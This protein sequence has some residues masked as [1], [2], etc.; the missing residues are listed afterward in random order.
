[1]ESNNTL[2]LSTG[3]AHLD[4]LL[5][6]DR[7]DISENGGILI[8]AGARRDDLETPIVVIEGTTGTGKTTLALQI[9]HSTA[10]N[11][12][13]TVFF[14]SLEQTIQSLKN[15]ALNFDS[16]KERNENT[17][18]AFNEI[19]EQP[20]VNFCDLS[21][22]EQ[23]LEFEAKENKIYFCHFSPRP[24]TRKE[25][26]D[27]F[28]QRIAE[29]NHVL[30]EVTAKID[31]S[32]FILF[33]V[34]SLTAFTG[35]SLQRNEIYRLFTVFRNYHIPA[36]V[37][38]ER[39]SVSSVEDEGMFECAR[40]LADIVIS[41]TKD[42]QVGY[43]QYFL[44]IVKSRICRQ[45]LG[46][47][48]YKI[49]T[50]PNAEDIKTDP[51]KGIVVYPSIHYVLSRVRQQIG[52]I[53][54]PGLTFKID[55]N[56]NEDLGL[57]LNNTLIKANS[58][59]AIIGPNGTHKLALG[60]NFAMG[61]LES[62]EPNV[63]IINFG[64]AGHIDFS[65]I[66]WTK[67]NQKWRRLEKMTPLQ[68]GSQIKFWHTCYAVKDEQGK[69]P[70]EPV[71]TITTFKIGQL[72][73]EECFDVV[74]SKL[75]EAHE[76]KHPYTSVL[77]YNT[78]ELCTGFPLLKTEPL[79]LP[80]LIDMCVV[81][82]VVSVSIGVENTVEAGNREANFALLANADFRI[83][84]SHY[85]Q[86]EELSRQIVES[87]KDNNKSTLEEQLVSLVIDN[88]T[89]KHYMRKPKWLWVEEISTRAK[90]TKK[91]LHC[92]DRPKIS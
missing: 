28:E 35:R 14:Y 71:A 73:P 44:E 13:W 67:F 69:L 37:T 89:G 42:T 75:R 78:A 92:Q 66:A 50:K 10:R 4:D 20:E 81:H 58:C 88:V 31:Q 60:L 53:E 48:L 77:L 2:Y 36:I 32:Y 91:I 16:F 26:K 55:E 84:L 7:E 47:H 54:E 11:E 57:V 34:D 86:I 12:E 56:R 82:Q 61:Y 19:K 21:K 43:L 68:L 90:L 70:A 23:E 74:E 8:G 6:P 25:E 65:G 24:F 18:D 52:A 59:I 41:L 9:A 80:T 39:Y 45:A 83:V 30:N 33:V 22:L 72:T 79:F 1:M 40:F 64:G 51:R 38:L 46:K 87:E 29:L 49:R 15:V 27:I 5:S 85:P 3:I 62:R 76:K 17:R 63:L